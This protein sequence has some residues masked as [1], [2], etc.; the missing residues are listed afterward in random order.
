MN[1]RKRIQQI[2]AT[3]FGM[4]SPKEKKIARVLQ[5]RISCQEIRFRVRRNRR[6]FNSERRNFFA[7]AV[8]PK[9]FPRETTLFL[10]GE[11][12]R[13][14]VTQDAIFRPRPV[15]PLFEMLERKRFLEPGIEHAVGKN[16]VRDIG[17]GVT[18][19]SG[20]AQILPDSVDDNAIVIAA[21]FAQPWRECARMSVTPDARAERMNRQ[22]GS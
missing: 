6:R 13:R 9:R 18:F 1:A 16:V 20:E 3:F 21:M 17:A 5:L 12:D 2:L 19:P 10:G 4:K 14:G 22:I 7:R 15:N 8:K 11:D